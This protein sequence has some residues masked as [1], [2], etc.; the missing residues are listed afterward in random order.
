MKNKV[1]VVEMLRWGDRSSH[2][3]ILGVYSKKHKAQ[4]EAKRCEVDRGGKY[5]ACITEIQL[6]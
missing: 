5:D 6:N 3:Y 4:K 2:S 1:W